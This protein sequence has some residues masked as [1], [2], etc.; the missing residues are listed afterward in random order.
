MLLVTCCKQNTDGSEVKLHTDG[1]EAG[2]WWHLVEHALQAA[3]RAVHHH[4][5]L[6]DH[7]DQHVLL[8]APAET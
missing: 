3:E 5:S 7:V 4:L 2:G 8:K 6:L 1:S